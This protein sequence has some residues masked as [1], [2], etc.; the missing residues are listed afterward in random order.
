M[1]LTSLFF[2]LSGISLPHEE[3]NLPVFSAPQSG[4]NHLN[5]SVFSF[6]QL[7]QNLLP[8]AGTS[9]GAAVPQFGQKAEPSGI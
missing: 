5:V 8:E 6:P 4:Q 9:L 7:L 1:R 2:T 3:Q